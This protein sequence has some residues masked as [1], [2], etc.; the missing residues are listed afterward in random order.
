L[1]LATTNNRQQTTNKKGAQ[2]GWTPFLFVEA[3]GIEP[4][5]KR[6]KHPKNKKIKKRGAA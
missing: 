6:P 5:A 4:H 3:G 1:G 2:H